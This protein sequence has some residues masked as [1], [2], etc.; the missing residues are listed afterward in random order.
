MFSVNFYESFHFVSQN[1]HTKAAEGYPSKMP[2]VSKKQL[3]AQMKRKTLNLKEKIKFIDFT[4][5]NPNFGCRTLGKIHR[6]GKTSVASILK[7][8]ENIRKEFQK[9]E[10]KSRVSVYFLKILFIGIILNELTFP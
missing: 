8:E 6:I 7:N 5:K 10:G 9:F 2:S 1:S 3:P 4:K